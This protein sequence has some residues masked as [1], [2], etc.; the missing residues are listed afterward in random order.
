MPNR[1]PSKRPP[2]FLS[3][4]VE[5]FPGGV[6]HLDRSLVFTF[7]NDVQ[8]SYF[9]LR[10]KDVIGKRLHD[11]APDS[12]DFWAEIERVIE[13]GEKYPQT[14]LAITWPGRIE[15]GEHHYL[16]SYIADRDVRQHVRGVFMTALEVT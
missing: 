10:T 8:A 1:T 16:V 5:A 11:V 6:A 9:G 3:R 12:P 15:E 7:C 13:T 2:P 14:A 4:L